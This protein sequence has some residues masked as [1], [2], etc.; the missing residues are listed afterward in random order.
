MSIST[1]NVSRVE[2]STM[3]TLSNSVI[4]SR[5]LL[6][7]YSNAPVSKLPSSLFSPDSSCASGFSTW[8]RMSL[9]SSFAE[10]T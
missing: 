8:M 10:N 9:F 3:N 5:T 1:W 4:T 2:L 6:S 7:L